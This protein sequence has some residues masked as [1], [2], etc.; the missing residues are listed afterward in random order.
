MQSKIQSTKASNRIEGI[1]TSDDISIPL[2]TISCNCTGICTHTAIPLFVLDFLCINTFN[3][4]NGRM[5]RLLTLLLLYRSGYIVGKYISMEMLIEKSKETYYE[6]LQE[7]SYLWHESENNYLPFLRYYL[8]VMVKG[9]REFQ[10]R[11]EHLQ[12]RNLS[13][14][15]RIKSVFDKKTGK[16]TK[17]EIISLCPDISQTT[18][19]RTLNE[20]LKSGYIE[21]TGK[22]KSTGYVK[23]NW[24]CCRKTHRSFGQIS[25]KTCPCIHE[26][27]FQQLFFYHCNKCYSL[28]YKFYSRRRRG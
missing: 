12:Y 17:S 8:G 1:F 16:I 9:Y 4:D 15:E 25:N 24:R 11:V 19:E 18:I 2:Q 28:F 14:S 21:K 13:K 7:S 26:E 10:D 23:N 5:S 6:A 27:C 20:L 3:D 22:G